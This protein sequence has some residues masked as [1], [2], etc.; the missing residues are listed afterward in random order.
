MHILLELLLVFGKI[1]L[2]GFGGGVAFLPLLEKEVVENH[3]WLAP[4]EFLDVV[5]LGNAS[6][7]LIAT[8]IAAQT[9]FKVAGIGGM[10]VSSISIGFPGAVILVVMAYFFAGMKDSPQIKAFLMGVRPAIF[11]LLMTTLVRLTKSS[12][13]DINQGV[14][15]ALAFF[16][17]WWFDVS[18]LYVILLSGAIGVALY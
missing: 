11:A 10:L 18:P 9:G 12:I 16:A 7:G 5:A 15:A 13:T 14:I 6:P 8:K 2:T 17:T 4:E 1:G 3:K